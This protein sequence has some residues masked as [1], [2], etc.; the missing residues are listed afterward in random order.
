MKSKWLVLVCLIGFTIYSCSESKS[1]S[2]NSQFDEANKVEA[3]VV[4]DCTG[5]YLR[6]NNKDYQVCNVDVLS[7][8]ESNSKIEVNYKS[9]S[10]CDWG[11]Q[12][13]CEMY[14]ENEGLIEITG[15]K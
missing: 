15:I 14:H 7:D 6:M 9:I 3:T 1:A 12:I 11:D 4:K 13:I 8:Y 10:T 2:L 5:S